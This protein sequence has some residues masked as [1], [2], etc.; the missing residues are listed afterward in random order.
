MAE[1]LG[2][3]AST[4]FVFPTYISTQSLEI[5]VSARQIKQKPHREKGPW[6]TVIVDGSENGI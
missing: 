4:F 1:L 5:D 6:P 2:D 3:I